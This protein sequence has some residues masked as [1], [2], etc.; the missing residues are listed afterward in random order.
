[1]NFPSMNQIRG[2]ALAAVILAGGSPH[3][4]AL[5]LNTDLLDIRQSLNFGSSV[6][7]GHLVTGRTSMISMVVGGTYR[8]S[9]PSS[10][11]GVIEG[12]NWRAQMSGS[13]NVLTV[14]VP[15]G[16]LPAERILPGFDNVPGGTTLQCSYTWTGAGRE[17]TYQLSAYGLGMSIGGGMTSQGDARVFEMYKPGRGTELDGSGCIH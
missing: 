16:Y 14:E 12:Y 3:A 4:Q 15:A 10:Y 13:P 5:N 1:M 17:A 2:V 9:C 6:V 7:L 11:T 8:V